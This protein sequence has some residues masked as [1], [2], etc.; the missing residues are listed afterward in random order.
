[1]YIENYFLNYHFIF[2]II[3]LDFI[4]NYTKNVIFIQNL[5]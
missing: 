3:I 4:Y 1:M 5:L 2:F